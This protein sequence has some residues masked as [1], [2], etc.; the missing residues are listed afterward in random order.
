MIGVEDANFTYEYEEYYKILPQINDWASD[1][2]RIKDGI[3]VPVD[4]EYTSENNVDWMTDNDL[5]AWLDKNLSTI[6]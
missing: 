1:T 6:D 4:F 5:L 3:K 2:N